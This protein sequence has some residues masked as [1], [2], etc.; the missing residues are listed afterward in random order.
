MGGPNRSSS[1]DRG[2]TVYAAKAR[3]LFLRRAR[4]VPLENCRGSGVT[5]SC[6]RDGSP[7][8]RNLS[9]TRHRDP[10]SIEPSA[11]RVSDRVRFTTARPDARLNLRKRRGLRRTC[12]I[13]PSRDR[14]H[15]LSGERRHVR[16]GATER[17]VGHRHRPARSRFSLRTDLR[18]TR[19]RRKS[20]LFT[21]G[22]NILIFAPRG[23]SP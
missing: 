6:V 15:G 16:I 10:P 5:G 17:A 7:Q 21:S 12:A 8:G 11:L 14:H 18:T 23:G 9:L 19:N 1:S 22:S 2:A 3:I 13:T 4:A 20:V